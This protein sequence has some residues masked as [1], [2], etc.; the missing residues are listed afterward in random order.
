MRTRILALA[1]LLA[2]IVG[3]ALACPAPTHPD[4]H[5]DDDSANP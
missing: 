1:A 4:D 5:G 3:L 2:M